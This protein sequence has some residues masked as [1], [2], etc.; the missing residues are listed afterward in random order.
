LFGSYFCTCNLLIS[1]DIP[2]KHFYKILRKSPQAKFHI[3]FILKNFKTLFRQKEINC[4]NPVT[5]RRC[6]RPSNQYLSEGETLK[7]N[8]KQK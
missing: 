3:S 6:G 1:F 8:K 2:C 5:S 4:T 7:Q